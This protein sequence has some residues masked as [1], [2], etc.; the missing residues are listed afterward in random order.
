[1]LEPAL[2]RG[3]R[4]DEDEAEGRDAVVVLGHDFWVSQYNA[5]PS[6]LGSQMRLDGIEFTVI[7]V[8][9]EQFTG[10]DQFVRPTLFI[11]LAMSPRMGQENNLHKRDARWLF[12]KG[13]LKPGVGLG[14]AQADVALIANELQKTY[15]RTNRDRRLKVE[16]ELQMRAE[17]SPP[18]ATMAGMLVLLGLCVL[19]VACAN[20]AG[21]LLSRS[22]ARSR[23]IAIRLAVGASRGSLVRQ[24]LFEN[25]L[26]AVA[27]G[28]GGVEVADAAT[29]FFNTYPIPTDLPI[30]FAAT[31]DNRVLLFTLVV[32]LVSTLLFG[33]APALALHASG[34]GAVAESGR[35]R[36]RRQEA[37]LGPKH[38]RGRS[39]GTF[40]GASGNLGGSAAGLPRPIDA[41]AG[42]PHRAPL[43]DQLRHGSGS[44]L[45]GPDQPVLQEAAGT[46]TLGPGR[47]VGRPY[48]RRF[49]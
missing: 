28:L 34:S 6:V 41:G 16:T 9:P 49:P 42:L 38:H 13:R 25:L 14:Q 44:L 12:V 15:P 29:K 47:A 11:P 4:P 30:A 22:R 8:A 32:S 48:L 40:A 1:M 18:T 17:Q 21:L 31:V 19:A 37:I 26:V 5:S 35:R 24:L 23:E 20:V 3:F 10:I 46:R 39:G 43:P 45:R 36:Q 27:G 33:L 2:G 7:G